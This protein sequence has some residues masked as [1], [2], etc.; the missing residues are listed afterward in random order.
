MPLFL[1][2]FLLNTKEDNSKM[3]KLRP[4]QYSRYFANDMIKCIY[5]GENFCILNSIS[6]LFVP[7]SRIDDYD[8]GDGLV[9]NRRKAVS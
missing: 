6:Q 2:L 1:F 5:L 7:V 8:P 3:S 4:E 9:T